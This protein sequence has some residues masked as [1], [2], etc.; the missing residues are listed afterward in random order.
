M[1]GTLRTRI[2]DQC[3]GVCS[4]SRQSRQMSSFKVYT[5]ILYGS[6]ASTSTLRFLRYLASILYG[7]RAPVVSSSI[8]TTTGPLVWSGIAAGVSVDGPMASL[9]L[10]LMSVGGAGFDAAVDAAGSSDNCA[11]VAGVSIDTGS[12]GWGACA[13]EV[14]AAGS[15]VGAGSVFI[16][17]GLDDSASWPLEGREVADVVGC[18]A[19]VE[20]W[21]DGDAMATGER[22][23]A[24]TSTQ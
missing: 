17:T 11:C 10:R 16:S 6:M 14:V 22:R 24:I 3:H 18:A 23:T 7:C 2:D 8:M 12:D 1:F 9:S 4:P 20:G 21:S 5:L 13:V 15:G 19:V